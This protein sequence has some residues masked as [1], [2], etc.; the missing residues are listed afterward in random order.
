[1][2]G[3]NK[4]IFNLRLYLR[5]CLAVPL[6]RRGWGETK[7]ITTCKTTKLTLRYLAKSCSL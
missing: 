1:M 3:F 2:E 6:L 4:G 7:K 5:F